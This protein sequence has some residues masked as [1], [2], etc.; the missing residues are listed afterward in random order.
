MSN[1]DIVANVGNGSRVDFSGGIVRI[2]RITSIVVVVVIYVICDRETTDKFKKTRSANA[3]ATVHIVTTIAAVV[4]T[5]TVTTT[6]N[7]AM[8]IT[9]PVY[10]VALVPCIE[11]VRTRVQL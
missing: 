2:R 11:K 5:I 10:L 6:A 7:A 8:M 3:K 9:T 4:T 1:G